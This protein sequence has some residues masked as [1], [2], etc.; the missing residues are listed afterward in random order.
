MQADG[1]QKAEKA[2]QQTLADET[3][4]QTTFRRQGIHNVE[5]AAE[6]SARPAVDQAL[7]QNTDRR[8]ANL[9][10]V[11]GAPPAATP[12]G[13]GGNAVVAGALDANRGRTNAMLSQTNAALANTGGWGDA[14]FGIQRAGQRSAEGVAQA[15]GNARGSGGTL[16]GRL[17][18]DA[19][20]G[21]NLR[22][23]GN[24]VVALGALAPGALSASGYGSGGGWLSAFGG[25]DGGFKSGGTGDLS[26]LAM[27][28]GGL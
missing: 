1:Q 21:S 15:I 26:G 2:R 17:A 8:E 23:A 22:T 12:N 13:I 4:R 6:Q 28:S 14:L 11:T 7:A 10:A 3:A 16:G 18:A 5:Q 27:S 19:Y 9:A 25:R 24:G 20:A